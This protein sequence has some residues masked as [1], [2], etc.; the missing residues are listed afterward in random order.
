MVLFLC[1]NASTLGP[2]KE[3]CFGGIEI[4]R[5]SFCPHSSSFFI[6]ILSSLYWFVSLGL[7]YCS[8]SFFRPLFVLHL[9]TP[10]SLGPSRFSV[11]FPISATC[12]VV[13]LGFFSLAMFTNPGAIPH[14]AQPLKGSVKNGDS[15]LLRCAMCHAYKP[16][17]SHHCK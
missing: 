15:L 16:M 17:K 11:S 2:R 7:S 14:C 4:G 10:F 9:Y 6:G 5:G 12:D 8:T 1:G 13:I 3:R